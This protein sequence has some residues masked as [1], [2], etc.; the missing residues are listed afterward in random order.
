[1]PREEFEARWDRPTAV[2]EVLEAATSVRLL[3]GDELAIQGGEPRRYVRLGHDALARVAADWRAELEERGR[4]EDERNARRR[5]FRRL[6]IGSLAI[7]CIAL[8]VALGALFVHGQNQRLTSAN[9]A[10]EDATKNANQAL[11]AARKADEEIRRQ[12]HLAQLQSMRSTFSQV[13]QLW[14][15]E[16][17][18]G[19]ALLLDSAIFPSEQD[20]DFVWGY[21]FARCNR[22]RVFKGHEGGVRAVAFSPD[23]RTL[24]SCSDDKTVR[25]WDPAAGETKATL[26]G[27]EGG[28]L[29]V[30]FSP[31]GR[32]LA[33]V[34]R[35][36]TVRVWDTDYPKDLP[37]QRESRE[38]R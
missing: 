35:D 27:H 19:R 26:K 37:A 6:L 12:A 25:L 10:L 34:G 31:D 8:L 13:D 24:A 20:R 1:M 22:V 29:D 9:T 4:L 14:R 5:Q 11:D 18:K 33:S 7:G 38:M 2:A 28:V 3:H 23:G 16:P 17:E 30:A 32:V 15:T 21:Y 36:K